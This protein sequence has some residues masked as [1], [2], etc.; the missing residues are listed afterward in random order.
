MYIVAWTDTM[1]AD[2]WMAFENLN[3]ARIYYS[4]LLDMDHAHMVSLL[5]VIESTS[6]SPSPCGDLEAV[7]KE[8]ETLSLHLQAD[9]AHLENAVLAEPMY[10][11]ADGVDEAINIIRRHLHA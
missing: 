3:E 7:I 5:S 9:G 8:L 11:K 4:G 1:S 2:Y 10:R 6:Y